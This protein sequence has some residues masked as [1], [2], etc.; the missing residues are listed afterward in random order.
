MPSPSLPAHPDLRIE[1]EET[2]WKGR[3]PLQLVRFR[4]R[5]F[6]GSFSGPRQWELW[7]RGRAAAA[8]PY[9][10]VADTVVLI[11]QFRLPALAA[12][13]DPVMVEVPA[14]LCEK[15]EPPEATIRREAQEEAGLEL[16]R[17]H[18][19]GDFVLTPGGADERATLFAGEVAAPACDAEGLVHYA[20]LVAENEDIRVRVCP[21][22]AAIEAAVSGAFANSVTA[23]ALLWLAARRDWLRA[24]WQA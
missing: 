6:D 15:D 2:V 24:A 17:L 3:F 7:R 4:N 23:I 19:I 20:G 11:D 8:L 18:L 12:G 21:A 16:K 14:G 1:S 10:P 5:R 22:E 13:V 9:D